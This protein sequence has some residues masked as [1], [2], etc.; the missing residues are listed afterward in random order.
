MAHEYATGTEGYLLPL[1]RNTA[2]NPDLEESMNRLQFSSLYY[3][4]RAFI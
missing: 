1:C 2:L 3:I 4:R